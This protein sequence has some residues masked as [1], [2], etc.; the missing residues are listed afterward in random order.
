MALGWQGL[1]AAWQA[2]QRGFRV[3]LYEMRP[4]NSTAAHKTDQCA[5]LVCSNSL[6]SNLPG[7]ASFLLKEELRHLDS[8]VIRA[9]DQNSV[10]AGAALAVDRKRFA[11]EITQAILDFRD[12]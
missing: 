6:G 5:E 9:A 3:I 12:K 4:H 10:P 11:N 7:S 1:K 8:L 2:A